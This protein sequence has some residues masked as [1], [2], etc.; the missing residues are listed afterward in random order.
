MT[1]R[2]G[3]LFLLFLPF[4]LHAQDKPALW[5]NLRFRY[6]PATADSLLIDSLSLVPGSLKVDGIP[7]EDY[8]L[9][10][11]RSLLVWQQKPARDSVF[12][13]Y[14]V[15][16]LSF[17]RRYFHKSASS[18]D[19]L[20]YM[21]Y[22]P[23]QGT[24]GTGNFVDLNEIEYNGSYGRSISV[25]NSQDVVL[26]SQFNLQ[27]NG[28]ILDSIKLEAAITDNTIPFQP[29]GNT[30]RLQEFDQLYIRF[31]K[32]KHS[33]QLG[34]Y[35]LERPPGYFLN[36]FK[37]VQGIYYQTELKAGK[38]GSNK[39]GLSGSVAKGEFARNI[40]QGLE[41][42]Q[43]PYKLTGNNAEQFFLVL[44]GTERVYVDNVLMER[45]ENADYIIN[46]NTAEV[47]FMPRKAI[48]KDSRIQ[49]EFEYQDRYYLNSLVYAYDEL[50]LGSKWNI[51]FNAYSNQDSKNQNY[52]QSL[53]GEQKRFLSGIGDS[54]QNAFF[55]NY[56][57]DT[58]AAD[59]I[60]YK[61]VDSTVDGVLYDTVF[62]YSTH[63]DSAR[64][65][66]S[67][68]F[69]GPGNGDY[70]I[71]S[72]NANGRVYDWVAPAGG[73]HRGDYAPV[74]LLITPKMQQVFTLVTNYRI[75]TFKN[76]NV[77]VGLSNYDP[78]LFSKRDNQAHWGAASRVTY[79]ER[80]LIGS[81][82]SSGNRKWDWQNAVSYEYVQDR[83]QAIAPYRNVEFGRD[84]NVPQLG[85]KPDEH[86]ADVKTSLQ[87]REAGTLS[88]QFTTYQRGSEYNGYRNIAGYT[89]DRKALRAGFMA[90]LLQSTDTGSTAQFF[91]PNVFAEYRIRSFLS[92][93]VGGNYS[94][95]HNAVRSRAGDTLLPTAFAFD[96]TN[97]Y[98]RT[99]DERRKLLLNYMLRRDMLPRGDAFEQQSHSHNISLQMGLSQWKDHRIGFTGTYRKLEIDNRSFNNQ[100]EEETL[101]GR[102]EYNGG[103]LKNAVTLNTLYE[104]GSG[105]EQRRAYTYVEV[106]AGQG[107]YTWI[108]YNNDGVQQI[109]EFELAQYPDQKKFIRVFTLTNEYVR[110][111]YITFNQ[112]LTL[113]PANLWR[114]NELRG[115][116]RFIARFSD[117]AS[118]QIAN[119]VLA[120]NGLR[121][122]NPFTDVLDNNSIIIVNRSV[123]NTLFYNR[124]NAGWGID[125]N[126][127]NNAG[128]Q[129]LTYGVEGSSNVQHWTKL[130]WNMTR[131]LTLNLSAK[132][133]TRQYQSALN[134]NRTYSVKASSGEPMLTWIHRSV[135]RI[136]ASAR[137]EDRRNAAAYGGEQAQIS[138]GN[139]ELRWS[140]PAVGALLLRGT[141]SGIAFDGSSGTSVSYYML[142]ALQKGD[143]FLWYAN[144]ERRVGKG[145]EV[146]LEYEGRKP[147]GGQVVHTGRMSLRA[148]L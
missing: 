131:S 26:N 19:S 126:Y 73:I 65:N 109:N 47:R 58:F 98:F 95:E 79:S 48:T 118:L 105:Q 71:S 117:Q 57:V 141:Y 75:D 4:A 92:S 14:R 85:P 102:L 36:Y 106:P 33:L 2:P 70:V 78:N 115:W 8:R 99:G 116:Q 60:L 40:F 28:Y 54:I 86:I 113:E 97:A 90:N 125:Y 63:P 25:G 114:K 23:D 9:F 32:N 143:N 31:T 34:D 64:Y 55:P 59:K 44:A 62:V 136:S 24:A 128:K 139:V 7:P 87:H 5:S 16:P 137:Y 42:N 146:S 132:T 12:I 135:L 29:E 41:G 35:N 11:E 84:W 67:F 130:R 56:P 134:D 81:A 13:S 15:L 83:F 144:W 50:Q 66:L 93:A 140:K 10:P 110:V 46:Y 111:N 100:N 1:R 123:N 124:T 119:R 61:L 27:V 18:V 6:F 148:I 53:S 17:S 80:R 38:N 45:G 89:Y 112:S 133:G 101:L 138:T 88:Y 129:L 20:Y 94:L 107:L 72:G 91:R 74:Q 108:D 52:L 68:S 49:V 37:R 77:E 122:Y 96:I 145:I 82:D 3:L 22:R 43:G 104:F 51:R 21:V 127:V 69:V 142:D 121:A 147:G 30:Q 76:V 103:L 39:L 120:G